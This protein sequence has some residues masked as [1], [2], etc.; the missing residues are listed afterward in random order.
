MK[1]VWID[2]SDILDLYYEF[3]CFQDSWT[4]KFSI[5]AFINIG[6]RITKF[7]LIKTGSSFPWNKRIQK[8][9]FWWCDHM[10]LS[11]RKQFN[12]ILL[13]WYV[14]TPTYVPFSRLNCRTN[15]HQILHTN[16]GKVLNTSLIPLTQPLDHGTP[17]SQ[18]QMGHRRENFM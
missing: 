8:F 2:W 11:S 16:S 6:C 1:L 12:L 3:S 4:E 7:V 14:Q 9:R 15:L 17:N 18:T 13:H 10:D 5:Q